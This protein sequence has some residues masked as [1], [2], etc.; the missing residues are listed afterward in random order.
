MP[1]DA[2]RKTGTPLTACGSGKLSITVKSD[3]G[4]EVE[5]LQAVVALHST[6]SSGD[7]FNKIREIIRGPVS[8]MTSILNQDQA[9][10]RA[11]WADWMDTLTPYPAD[12]VR[13][14][15]QIFKRFGRRYVTPPDI[16]EIIEEKRQDA[17][18]R[19]AAIEKRQR[20]EAEDEELAWRRANRVKPERAHNILEEYGFANPSSPA[21]VVSSIGSAKRFGPDP[22]G[23]DQ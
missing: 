14:A 3:L 9:T 1:W 21:S 20:E 12:L 23:S 16:V 4:R 22:E 17:A 7:H 8:N 13:E 10:Q 2:N 11:M 19:L 18:V 15:F 6:T 5:E